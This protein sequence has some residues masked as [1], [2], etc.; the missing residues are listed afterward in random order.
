MHV[1]KRIRRRATASHARAAHVR[2]GIGAGL[3]GWVGPGDS[4][5][6]RVVVEAQGG[7]AVQI[8]QG[9]SDAG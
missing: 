4:L 2:Q 3:L 8:G 1:M 7:L 6:L 9:G 5:G